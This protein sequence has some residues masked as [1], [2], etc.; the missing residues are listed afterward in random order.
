MSDSR[1]R[2]RRAIRW[3][4]ALVAAGLGLYMI[5]LPT[6]AWLWQ[7]Q[8]PDQPS[9]RRVEDPSLTEQ[10]RIA[11]TKMV[12][13]S[14]AFY[15][16]AMAGS[17]LNV[18]AYRAPRGESVVRNSSRC[19][20]CG[21]RLP[22]KE[23]LPIFGWLLLEGRCSNCQTAIPVRYL[24]IEL[25]AGGLFLVLFLTELI[26]GGANLPLREP[27]L[28][29]GVVWV[30]LY[31]KWD[32]IGLYT[33]HS[34]LM[35]LTLAWVLIA[36]QR[37]QVP[38]WG[39]LVSTA[40]VG[41]AAVAGGYLQMPAW[42]NSARPLMPTGWVASTVASSMGGALGLLLAVLWA[43]WP[44]SQQLPDGSLQQNRIRGMARAI[45]VGVPLGIGLGWQAL[46]GGWLIAMLLR[47]GVGLVRCGRDVGSW[48]IAG[49]LWL[50]TLLQLVLWRTL[51][52][53]L[54]PWWPGP[55]P[56][57]QT[58]LLLVGIGGG[59]SNLHSRWLISQPM[60]PAVEEDSDQVNPSH[61]EADADRD[62]SISPDTVLP[63]TDQN[64]A[65]DAEIGDDQAAGRRATLGEPDG[66]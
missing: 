27:N 65:V 53:Q 17:F 59:L 25:L 57:W 49:Y 41:V 48:P 22:L 34:L 54:D 28:Y 23:N 40:A 66:D 24:G 63:D 19:P 14:L 3:G 29:S 9:M 55:A 60:L 43:G 7:M 64:R 10:V 6:A 44:E 61:I 18:V 38:R 21:H 30:L 52:L 51:Y 16:G 8:Q 36:W 32:L 2:R 47:S 15:L 11:A 31:P 58:A 20:R 35:S 39:W 26:S 56:G 45:S 37:Q 12:V 5:V 42:D 33:F 62:A 46:A 4:L 13:G 50:G 1:A